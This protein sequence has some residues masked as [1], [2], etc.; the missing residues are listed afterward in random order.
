MAKEEDAFW[1]TGKCSG[2]MY[3][4]DHEHYDFMNEAFGL[5]AH[6]NVLQRD[7]CPSATKFEGEILVDGARPVPRRRRHRRRAR[8]PR[9]HRRHRQHPP[10]RPR[11]PRAGG[12]DPRRHP[13][14]LR[15]ARDRPPRVRQGLPPV[16]HRGAQ[17]ARRPRHHA[18]RRRRRGRPASTTRPS[19]SW[20]RPATTPTARSTPSP[21]WASWPRAGASGCTSTA[22][23][24]GSSSR[25]ARSSASTIPSFDFRVPG[26]TSISA[27]THKY[28]YAFKGS[29]TLLFRDKALRNG[30]YFFLSGWTGGKYMSPGIEGSRSGGLLAATWAAMVQLG[31]DGYRRYAE[32]IFATAGR[33][34]GRRAVAPRAADHG[35]PH[36]LLLVHFTVA[37]TI[38]HLPRERLH[39]A[40]G[41]AVQR[42][43]VPER[44]PHGRH[45]ARR[46]SRAWPRRSP[47]TWPTPSPTPRA[48]DETPLQRR[49]LRRR[50]RRPHRRGRRASSG[51]SWPTC[52]T[53]QA[54]IPS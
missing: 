10:R 15:Q 20:A 33:D 8:R 26:V 2:T 41:L 39:A 1:E 53:E 12:R 49:H 14:Q 48:R 5:Y 35:Q 19:P 34:E 27:D 7:M 43:A 31:R 54:R 40:A 25:S 16:R 9:H 21:S 13:A 23:S 45:P 51:G 37:T 3:C 17:G 29:S 50:G 46:P 42:P 11:L 32:Q 22:A 38:R 44:H 28:G 6:V 24:A 18:G 30:Q 52:S 36:V 47:P 4:G